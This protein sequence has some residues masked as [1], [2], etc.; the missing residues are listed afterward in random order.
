MSGFT[1]PVGALISGAVSVL[2]ANVSTP[3]I[4]WPLVEP[5]VIVGPINAPVTVLT[6][7][8]FG[9]AFMICVDR[10]DEGRFE[11]TNR[12]F[13]APKQCDVRVTEDG[14]PQH[15]AEQALLQIRPAFDPQAPAALFVGRYQPFHFGHQRLIEEGLRRVGQV[16]GR[17]STPTAPM[18]RTVAVL[19]SEAPY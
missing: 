4:A 3:V 15:W 19:C 1:I 8:A 6:R 9:E 14:S 13:V 16:C 17:C 5:A 7:A 10:I 12:L 2:F 11:D 18:R